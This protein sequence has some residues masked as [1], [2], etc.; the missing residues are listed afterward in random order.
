VD[1]ERTRMQALPLE[2]ARR[3]PPALQFLSIQRIPANEQRLFTNP[4]H[5][6]RHILANESWLCAAPPGFQSRGGHESDMNDNDCGHFA[7]RGIKTRTQADWR[8]EHDA[9]NAGA[10]YAD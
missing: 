9:H 6:V 10:P 4:L 5:G 2:R 3:R 7:R 1:I 8:A